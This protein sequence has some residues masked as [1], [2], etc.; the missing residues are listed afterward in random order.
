[1]NLFQI[2][3]TKDGR[4]VV[5]FAKSPEAQ[6]ILTPLMSQLFSIACGLSAPIQLE[7]TGS[8]E[9]TRAAKRGRKLNTEDAIKLTLVNKPSATEGN[10]QKAL[11]YEYDREKLTPLQRMHDDQRL[12][13]DVRMREYCKEYHGSSEDRV[14]YTTYTRMYRLFTAERGYYPSRRSPMPYLNLLAPTKLNTLLIDGMGKDF[15]SFINREI[16]KLKSVR[17]K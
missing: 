4:M 12:E 16:R 9:D 2:G 15:I 17:S 6:A 7:Q 1:M 8:T 3:T 10:K 11:Q 13:I 5:T 14:V